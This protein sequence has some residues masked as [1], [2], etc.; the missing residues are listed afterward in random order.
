LLTT[1]PVV[2]TVNLIRLAPRRDSDDAPAHREF[3]RAARADK[4]R[5]KIIS[6][7]PSSRPL[8][9]GQAAGPA[10]SFVYLLVPPR[11]VALSVAEHVFG[12]E[13]LGVRAR[14]SAHAEH[15]HRRILRDDL[16]DAIQHNLQFGGKAADRIQPLHVV[17]DRLGAVG[18]L[19]DRLESA[20][21][22]TE[23]ILPC[24][25]SPFSGHPNRRDDEFTAGPPA[26]AWAAAIASLH[27]EADAPLPPVT[28]P[29]PAAEKPPDEAEAT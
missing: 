8:P 26:A 27:S 23:R 15:D 5:A 6:L 19:A 25:T 1:I 18:R 20:R 7:N 3:K 12:K 4:L 2:P 14:P 29:A 10:P 16:G 17:P 11:L 13:I 22:R 21:P 9:A 24:S 28:P